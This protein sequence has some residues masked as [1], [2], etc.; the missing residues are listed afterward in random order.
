MK[1]FERVIRILNNFLMDAFSRFFNV[2]EFLQHDKNSSYFSEFDG[3]CRL[4]VEPKFDSASYTFAFK[5]LF[6]YS[7]VRSLTRSRENAHFSPENAKR[8]GEDERA[9]SRIKYVVSRG[10]SLSVPFWQRLAVLR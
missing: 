6:V 5:R 8:P 10:V 7:F 9:E 2:C 4:D 3:I 1:Y